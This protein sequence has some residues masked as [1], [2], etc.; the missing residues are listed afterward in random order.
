M[1]NNGKT[2]TSLQLV[3]QKLGGKSSIM[4]DTL[5]RLQE[6]GIKSSKSTLYQAIAGRTHRQELVEVFLE[7]AE[8]EFERRRQVEERARQLIDKD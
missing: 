6:R 8:E 3:L 1:E 7:L 5:D 4:R 2:P